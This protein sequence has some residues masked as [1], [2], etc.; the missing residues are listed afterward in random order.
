MTTRQVAIY[1]STKEEGLYLFVDP[2]EG[3]HRVP[4]D[5][6]QRFG[7][8]EFAM[9]LELGP[10]RKLARA[11]AARVLQAIAEQGF[12]LQLPPTRD[13]YMHEV[14]ANNHKL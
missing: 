2:A 4:E 6:V 10:E 8:A 1:R 11:N 13:D 3:L 5:L 7:R 9:T 14:R 12:Y